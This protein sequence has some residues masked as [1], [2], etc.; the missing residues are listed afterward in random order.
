MTAIQHSANFFNWFSKAG[1]NFQNFDYQRTIEHANFRPLLFSSLKINP[2]RTKRLY[3]YK[4]KKD[5]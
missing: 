2:E 3:N 5:V 1:G 4:F